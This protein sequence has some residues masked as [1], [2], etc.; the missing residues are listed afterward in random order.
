MEQASLALRQCPF[1]HKVASQHGEEYAR[2]LAICPTASAAH[3]PPVGSD[4]AQLYAESFQLFHGP[5]GIVPLVGSSGKGS[6]CPFHAQALA[7]QPKD[8]EA[9]GK[10]KAVPPHAPP[11]A[12]ISFS[13]G[14]GPNF[15]DFF[16]NKLK[17]NNSNSKPQRSQGPGHGRPPNHPGA[18]GS[19]TGSNAGPAGNSTQHPASNLN[20]HFEKFSTGWFIAVH[21]TIPFVAMLR[22]AVIMPKY[23]MVVTIAAA[24][25]GQMGKGFSSYAAAFAEKQ[26]AQEPTTLWTGCGAG[27]VTGLG[28]LLPQLPVV[29]V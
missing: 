10:P 17:H 29:L 19:G 26:E 7:K 27:L 18:G 21:A 28:S 20:K 23:A 25:L 2:N 6:G 3:G 22:K 12:T 16:R 8:Q 15:G 5:Q 4:H 9:C 14:S 1:L 24:V 11:L 13:L